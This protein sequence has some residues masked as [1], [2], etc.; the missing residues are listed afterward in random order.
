MHCKGKQFCHKCCCFFL[1]KGV[2]YKRKE[3]A[4]RRRE[5]FFPFYNRPF[6]RRQTEH[7]EDEERKFVTFTVDPFLE[8]THNTFERR[9]LSS[10]VRAFSSERVGEQKSKQEDT[11][12]VSRVKFAE[13][14]RS[15]LTIVLLNPDVPCLCKQ[16][17]SRSVGFWRTQLI[18]ICTVCH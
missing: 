10:F 8:E 11:K 7:F 3:F 16:C 15:V 1:L 14:V 17:R 4:P 9:I 5:K 6:F 12:V 2:Y 13:K 18:W